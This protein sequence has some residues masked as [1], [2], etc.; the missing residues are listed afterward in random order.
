MAIR[1]PITATKLR[2]FLSQPIPQDKD[3]FLRGPEGF[4]VRRYKGTGAAS[5]IVEARIRGLNKS[6]QIP[7][8][9]ATP[10]LLSDAKETAHL[11]YSRMRSGED[12]KQTLKREQTERSAQAVSLESALDHLLNNPAETIKLNT[13][14]MYRDTIKNSAGQLR[15]KRI[16]D[17]TIANTRDQIRKIEGEKSAASARKLRATLSRVIGYAIT[18]WGLPM[19]NPIRELK[20]VG[21]AA[22]PRQ[23]FIPDNW[24]GH[25]VERLFQIAQRNPT[26]GNYLLF[27]LATGCRK[28]EA[29]TLEWPDVNWDQLSITFRDTKNGKDH[30]LPISNLMDT[31]LREQTKLRRGNSPWV[32][33]GRVHGTRLNDVRK[34]LANEIDTE[35]LW[36]PREER[37]RRAKQAQGVTL[38]VH[39]LRRTAAT[40]M[41][42]AGIPKERVSLILNHGGQHITDRYIQQNFQSIMRSL[43]EYHAWLLRKTDDIPLN[44]RRVREELLT[45]SLQGRLRR[46]GMDPDPHDA[47]LEGGDSGNVVVPDYWTQRNKLRKEQHERRRKERQG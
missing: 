24:I 18:E 36:L 7:L 21:K 46:M 20:G 23:G 2:K 14:K 40:H 12:V 32:F 47:I 4:G 35:W 17:L 37:E 39:D 43:N 31:I 44:G 34:T 8:G 30:Y 22:A 25:L 15:R 28:E 10:E 1:E 41:E 42:G 45:P 19:Q 13:A 16:M 11:Y 38:I 6:D 9:P 27:V 3:Q 29:M 33:P 26:H 5:F